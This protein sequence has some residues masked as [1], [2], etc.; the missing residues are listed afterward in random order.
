MSMEDIPAE[1]TINWDQSSLN[2]VPTPNWTF[3]E[4]GIKRI[5]IVGLDDKR[6]IIILLSHSMNGKL[7]LTQVI[8]AG[9][10]MHVYRKYPILKAGIYATQETTGL[11]RTL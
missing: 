9:K 1:L 2:Y 10:T 5:E 8:Y 11:M 4:K 6:A 3:E 7:L